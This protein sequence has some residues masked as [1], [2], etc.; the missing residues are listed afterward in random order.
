[1]RRGMFKRRIKSLLHLVENVR[2]CK[3]KHDL[4]NSGNNDKVR[5]VN[6]G[7]KGHY[8]Q[9]DLLVKLKGF[10]TPVEFELTRSKHPESKQGTCSAAFKTPKK[11]PGLLLATWHVLMEVAHNETLCPEKVK[12]WYQDI[13]AKYGDSEVPQAKKQSPDATIDWGNLHSQDCL[14]LLNI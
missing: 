3:H 1:M 2:D 14:S 13:V 11:E 4:E 6:Y 5:G 10:S 12:E 7:R 8:L 9:R